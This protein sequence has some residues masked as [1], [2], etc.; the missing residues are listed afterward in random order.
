MQLLRMFSNEKY[1]G[2][3]GY[4]DSQKKYEVMRTI[5]YFG[6]SLSL[7]I[8]GWVTTGSRLNL[9]T[10]VAV[11]GCLPASKST[12]G[13]IMFLRFH[14]CPEAVA[15]EIE[16]HVGELYGMYDLVFTSYDKNYQVDHMV[17]K[18]NTVCGFAGGEKFDEQK[19]YKHIDRVLKAEN[20]TDVSVKIFDDVRKYLNRLEQMKTLD[21]DEES[22]EGI[23]GTFR[24]VAL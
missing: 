8:A 15:E 18:G 3:K 16:A 14:S 20:Y 2:T 7:F 12:V 13:M 10:V 17:V 1:K 11:L 21:A 6:I 4:L 5:L 22:T 24:S 23:A 19:F 9:L